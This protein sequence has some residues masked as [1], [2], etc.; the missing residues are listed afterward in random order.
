MKNIG[1]VATHWRDA[2]FGS[3]DP[4][5]F[6]YLESRSENETPDIPTARLLSVGSF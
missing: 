3:V 4:A 6:A 2:D 5:G 1:V